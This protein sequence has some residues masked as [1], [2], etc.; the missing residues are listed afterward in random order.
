MVPSTSPLLT[1]NVVIGTLSWPRIELFIL[2]TFNSPFGRYRFLRM[3]F[4][5]KMLQDVFQAK[6]HQTYEGWE[7]TSG[8]ADGIVIFGSRNTNTINT[9]MVCWQDVGILCWSSAQK[10]ARLNRRSLHS[11]VSFLVKMVFN[12]TQARYQLWSRQMA[13]LLLNRNYRHSLDYQPT[14]VYSFPAAAHWQPLVEN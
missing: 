10:N 14:W 3:P 5:L 13:P 6:I 2:T 7:G 9:F 8:I 4:S 1:R 12:Q 11:M